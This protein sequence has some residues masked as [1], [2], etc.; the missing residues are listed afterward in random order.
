MRLWVRVRQ[1]IGWHGARSR[2]GQTHL[3]GCSFSCSRPEAK[4]EPLVA[5]GRDGE[6][7][8]RGSNR[9][10]AL[11]LGRE[12]RLV[13]AGYV[14]DS[15]VSAL[16]LSSTRSLARQPRKTPRETGGRGAGGRPPA[17]PT[18]QITASN[19]LPPVRSPVDA[20]PCFLPLACCYIH[21]PSALG[22]TWRRRCGGAAAAPG[23]R[24]TGPA[25]QP[26]RNPSPRAI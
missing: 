7:H 15:A 18:R 19:R 9:R 21:S 26:P 20:V 14:Q 6:V 2:Q 23:G 25:A 11:S 12:I 17:G 5:A 10:D 8:S 24:K 13:C 22:T 1:R 4:E 3:G 16:G